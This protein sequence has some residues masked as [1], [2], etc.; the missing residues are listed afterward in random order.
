APNTT[1]QADR[2]AAAEL[3]KGFEPAAIEARWYPEWERRGYFRSGQH[4]AN[5]SA[6]TFAIQLQP[7]NVTGTLRMG[8]GFN[9][10]IMDGLT[11]YF[12]MRGA[13]TAWIPGTY[14]AGIATQIVVERQLDAQQISRHDLGRERFVEKVWEW[15]QYSGG[16]I[17]TQ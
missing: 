16:T 4:V 8:H 9:Q 12:R 13:D 7:P 11:R 15:K 1:Q 14:H 5:G 10:T 3:S 17:T 6:E 2:A